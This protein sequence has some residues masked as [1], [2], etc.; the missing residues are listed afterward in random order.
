MISWPHCL[1][2]MVRQ[3]ITLGALTT[4]TMKQ[5]KKVEGARV[6]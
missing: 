2:A 5:R 6:P 3:Y 4:L 1:G